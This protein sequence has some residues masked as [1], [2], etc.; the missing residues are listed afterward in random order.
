M[1]PEKGT[2]IQNRVS[3]VAPQDMA[4]FKEKYV[5]IHNIYFTGASTIN[6]GILRTLDNQPLRISLEQLMMGERKGNEN[7]LCDSELIANC[8]TFCS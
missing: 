2:Y 3:Q 7:H 6:H 5:F 4:C 8:G 1:E